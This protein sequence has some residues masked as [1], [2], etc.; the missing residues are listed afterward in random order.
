MCAQ[1]PSTPAYQHKPAEKLQKAGAPTE[2]NT[3]PQ[4]STCSLG[5]GVFQR[6]TGEEHPPGAGRPARMTLSGSQ[7]RSLPA[8]CPFGIC[9]NRNNF[10]AIL[11]P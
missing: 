7:T 8:S 9:T 2:D 3:G 4:I 11:L 1:L 10:P 5:F 6:D